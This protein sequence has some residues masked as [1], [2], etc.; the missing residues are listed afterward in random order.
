MAATKYLDQAGLTYLWNKIKSYVGD[1]ID[2]IFYFKK[3]SGVNGSNQST[4]SDASSNLSEIVFANG[5]GKSSLVLSEQT[6]GSGTNTVSKAVITLNSPNSLSDLDSTA[7]TKL[8]GIA[9]GAEVN[10]NAFSN[11]KV[12]ST[13]IAADGKTDTLELV[14]GTGIALTPDATNDKVT[15]A[16]TGMQAALSN[17]P[18]TAVCSSGGMNTVELFVSNGTSTI[19]TT[20]KQIVRSSCTDKYQ[21]SNAAYGD[22]YIPTVKTVSAMVAD[23]TAGFA[24]TS[25]LNATKIVLG[26]AN[27]ATTEAS[28]GTASPFMNLVVNSAVKSS[29]KIVGAGAASVTFASGELVVGATDTK[30]TAG[31]TC[32]T[33]KLYLVG[34]STTPPSSATLTG[35]TKAN[36]KAF[37][38]AGKLYS[39][40][41]ETATVSDT[42]TLTNKTLTAA[43]ATASPDQTSNDTT[44]ATTAFVQTLVA[45]QVS[46]AVAFQGTLTTNAAITALQNYH[47]GW[48]W[49]INA[50]ITNTDFGDLQQGDMLY[51]IANASGTYGNATGLYNKDDFSVVQT[52]MAPLSTTEIDSATDNTPN[53]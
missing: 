2:N 18:V 21:A 34:S 29:Y 24:T 7:A 53:S 52:D 28:S 41:N 12:G 46:G 33:G 6:T 51:A 47:A 1:G 22:C 11:V 32:S 37:I 15:I 27:N 38:N 45:N 19:D 8:G 49:L 25:T 30:N 26:D 44:L 36:Q 9:T 16:T 14:A 5:T 23:L 17:G 31:L 39:N 35:A 3:I 50:A 48:Y 43:H 13:T 20:V 10:Q 4:S 40:G 42:Q